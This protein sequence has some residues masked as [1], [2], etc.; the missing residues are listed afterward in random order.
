ML[1][2]LDTREY[3][4]VTDEIKGMQGQRHSCIKS[5]TVTLK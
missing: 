2:T 3:A 1:C 4:E 5:K